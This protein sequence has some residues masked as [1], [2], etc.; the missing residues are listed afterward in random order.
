MEMVPVAVVEG[1][2]DG[3]L[4]DRPVSERRKQAVEGQGTPVPAQDLEMLGKASWTDAQQL[5][6]GRRVRDAMIEKDRAARGPARDP[7]SQS[8][9]EPSDSEPRAH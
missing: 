7:P 1:H 5:R 9:P 2:R 6:I 3:V 4:R 8:A